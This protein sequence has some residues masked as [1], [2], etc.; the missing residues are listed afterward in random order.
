M[1]TMP[2][3]A[4]QVPCHGVISPEPR[5]GSAANFFTTVRPADLRLRYFCLFLMIAPL[6]RSAS[7]GMGNVRLT[8]A[9][10][11]SDVFRLEVPFPALSATP[12]KRRVRVARKERH[13]GL[14]PSRHLTG[15]SLRTIGRRLSS[16]QMKKAA[17]DRRP[18]ER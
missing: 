5:G 1:A 11:A 13:G 3:L 16:A 4:L 7:A 2:P 12:S 14:H 15:R 18:L 17:D 8:G 9:P 10:A 6:E